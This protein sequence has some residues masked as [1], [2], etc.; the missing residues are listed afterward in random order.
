[1]SGASTTIELLKVAHGSSILTLLHSFRLSA[2]LFVQS[3]TPRDRLAQGLTLCVKVFYLRISP[4]CK[5][6]LFLLLM[7]TMIVLTLSI[8]ASEPATFPRSKNLVLA[9]D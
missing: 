4:G 5:D 1:M 6:R 7:M 8:R 3:V 2:M 9:R